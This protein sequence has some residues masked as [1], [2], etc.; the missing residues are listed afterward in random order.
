M[1]SS[2]YRFGPFVLDRSEFRLR[3]EARAIDLPPKALDVLL[4]L[5]ER[6]GVLFT[7]EE[8]FE[9]VWPDVAVTDN[10]LTQVICGI[11]Q[12]L[13][14]SP[15]SPTYLQTVARRGY[16]FIGT[17][18]AVPPA[19]SVRQRGRA[20]RRQDAARPPGT[21]RPRLCERE[22]RRGPCLAVGGHR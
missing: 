20:D 5:V 4:H 15:A 21:R 11:R 18:E 10:A 12:A 17:V 2:A 6:P 22:P 13:G 14:D 3:R 7:K 1:A 8:L 19:A 9:R 16:R